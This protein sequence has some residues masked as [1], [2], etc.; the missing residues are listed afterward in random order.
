MREESEYQVLH[1]QREDEPYQVLH[2]PRE[3]EPYQVFDMKTNKMIELNKAQPDQMIELNKMREKYGVGEKAAEFAVNFQNSFFTALNRGQFFQNDNSELPED[4]KPFFVMNVPSP[5]P[6]T[7]EEK[8]V[9]MQ[10]TAE[11]SSVNVAS[12]NNTARNRNRVHRAAGNETTAAFQT[13]NNSSDPWKNCNENNLAHP[14][15]YFGFWR[16]TK[17]EIR[18]EKLDLNRDAILKFT[19]GNL[20]EPKPEITYRVTSNGVDNHVITISEYT[21]KDDTQP[22]PGPDALKTLIGGMKERNKEPTGWLV[23]WYADIWRCQLAREPINYS[24]YNFGGEQ[25]WEDHNYSYICPD[26]FDYM[27]I[28]VD[29]RYGFEISSLRITLNGVIIYEKK[30][31]YADPPTI[32]RFQPIVLDKMLQNYKHKSLVYDHDMSPNDPSIGY[33]KILILQNKILSIA[34]SELGQSWSP[35]YAP[36]ARWW[37]ESS[38]TGNKW[39]TAPENWCADFAGWLIEQANPSLPVSKVPYLLG[40][41]P[42]FFKKKSRWISASN[43]PYEEL[44]NVIEPGFVASTRHGGHTVIFLYW[45]GALG[46]KENCIGLMDL[47]EK[48]EPWD[49]DDAKQIYQ[50]IEDAREEVNDTFGAV[51]PDPPPGR[52]E[53]VFPVNWFLV[54]NG[55]AG[56]GRVKKSLTPV[57]KLRKRDIENMDRA[58]LLTLFGNGNKKSGSEAVLYSEKGNWTDIRNWRFTV[59]PGSVVWWEDGFG[60]TSGISSGI[61]LE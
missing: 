16:G 14:P 50:A 15:W 19:F 49:V 33:N 10:Q 9:F 23:V 36:E 44:G 26:L 28:S 34:S 40:E 45:L 12:F 41:F 48:D 4:N 58:A 43:T 38:V 11:L 20:R 17:I 42:E 6:A 21:G 46:P 2:V 30:G 56:G 31:L 18:G 53:P 54:I 51:N 13:V 60:D 37:K 55:N 52:F 29:S 1:V 3:D 61:Q 27:T 47:Y 32:R 5:P 57:I 39:Y 22:I 7:V 25:N 59:Y 35:K 8:Y 24:D